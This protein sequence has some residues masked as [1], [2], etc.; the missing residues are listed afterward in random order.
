MFKSLH[1][2]AQNGLSSSLDISAVIAIN[3]CT[4]SCPTSPQQQLGAVLF[5]GPYSPVQTELGYAAQ[6]YTVKLPSSLP[7]GQ[8]V[9]LTA[10]HFG[11]IGVGVSYRHL[12]WANRLTLL[13]TGW[14]DS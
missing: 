3:T 13:G 4:T 2:H 8:D 5:A 6:N 11:L 9:L 7:T 10:L 14:T 1:Q 12:S